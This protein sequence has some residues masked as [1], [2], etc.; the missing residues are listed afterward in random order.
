MSTYLVLLNV[1]AIH[2][3]V[4][5]SGSLSCHAVFMTAVKKR[6]KAYRGETISSSILQ[7]FLEGCVL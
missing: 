2:Y 1:R 4:F 5:L 6:G 3:E 7:T